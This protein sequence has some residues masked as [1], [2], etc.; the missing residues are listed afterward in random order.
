M[1]IDPDVGQAFTSREHRI[2]GKNEDAKVVGAFRAAF[3]FGGRFFVFLRP[4]DFAVF[5]FWSPS[6]AAARRSERNVL[7]DKRRRG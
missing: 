3:G 2:S 1:T 4:V 6:F 7:L 5:I